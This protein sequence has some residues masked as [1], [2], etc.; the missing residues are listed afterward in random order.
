MIESGNAAADYN[1][2]GLVDIYLGRYLD[3][4][5]NIPTTSFYT[6]NGEGNTLLRNDGDFGFRELQSG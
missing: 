6:R 4:R 3:P 5:T 1:N 2:D